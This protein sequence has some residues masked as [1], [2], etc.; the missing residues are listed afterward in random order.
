MSAGAFA[1]ALIL[2]AI[3]ALVA[4]WDAVA[5]FAADP[6]ATISSIV[7][8]WSRDFPSIPFFA[9]FLFGH[10]FFPSRMP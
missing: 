1:L 5:L 6:S 2:A 7:I 4:V 10:L 9:G 8:G 3:L